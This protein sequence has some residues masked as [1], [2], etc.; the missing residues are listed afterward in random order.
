MFYIFW[1]GGVY[2]RNPQEGK[3][4]VEC[5]RTTPDQWMGGG[6]PWFHPKYVKGVSVDMKVLLD[7][8]APILL[9]IVSLFLRKFR[10]IPSH[11]R[12]LMQG[13]LFSPKSGNNYPYKLIIENIW[14]ENGRELPT[15]NKHSQCCWNKQ[16]PLPLCVPAL[17]APVYGVWNWRVEVI[18][19]SI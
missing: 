12:I 16:D 5:C 7:S 6:Y 8:S 15:Q 1:M 2:L 9:A 10:N 17:G 3:G 18:F 4:E 19:L 13:A 11:H 14:R